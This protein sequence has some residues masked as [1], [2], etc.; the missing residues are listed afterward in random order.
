MD[1]SSI[2]K[3]KNFLLLWAGQTVS[4]LGDR[5]LQIALIWYI[6]E[7]TGSSMAL[8]VS[9]ICFTVPMVLVQPIAGIFAD[10]NVKKQIIVTSDYLNSFMMFVIALLLFSGELPL[11]YLYILIAFS[12]S[13]TAFFTPAIQSS[14]PL[15]VAE[16]SLPKANSLNQFSIHMSN[17]LGPV[18]AGVLIGFMDLWLLLFMSGIAFFISACTE[19]WISIPKVE[20]NKEGTRFGKRFKE[21][22][23]YLMKN[24]HLLYLVFVGGIIINFLL[25]P[26][27]VYLTILSSDVLEVG[28]TGFG[29]MNTFI[30]VGAITGILLMFLNVFKDKFKMVIIGLSLEGVALLIMGTVT[31]F[32]VSLAG[33]FVLG[34]GLTLASV[35][36]TTLYQTIIPKEKMGRV[37]SLVST[38]LL[39]VVP[40]GTLVGS[41][42]V[43]YLDLEL[44]LILS[45]SLVTVSG[46]SLIFLLLKVTNRS[47]KEESNLQERGMRA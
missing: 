36:I 46:L 4:K 42:A 31:V 30:S 44:I 27:S 13:I 40:I 12:S 21:G 35:G 23:T 22:F 34:L 19:I 14:I 2:W 39:T 28:S 1:N 7:Q 18:L 15:I 29:M 9:L 6:Y 33:L 43:N 24:T 5:F 8:G 10:L 32:Y 45:G 38:A 47:L 41:M 17:I 26:L 11:L 20:G 25:A 16:E 37:M 3:N